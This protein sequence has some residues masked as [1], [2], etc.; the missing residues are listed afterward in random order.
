MDFSEIISVINPELNEVESEL[1]QNIESPVPL[2]YEISKYLLGSGGKR[3]RPAVLLLASGASGLT[4]GKERIYAGAALNPSEPPTPWQGGAGGMQTFS[5]HL[6]EL[7]KEGL[8]APQTS[9][10][11]ERDGG[12]TGKG[13]R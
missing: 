5:Q 10:A 2:V 6:T 13:R 4:N 9:R 11:L 1:E 7:V 3:L 8:V 12:A